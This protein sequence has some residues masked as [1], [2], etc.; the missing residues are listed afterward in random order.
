MLPATL[1]YEE[2]DP[3]CPITVAAGAPRATTHRYAVK[4]A[5]TEMGQCAAA[6]V[7]KWD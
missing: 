6:V 3:E 4:V 2:P 1:N 5:F 7:R